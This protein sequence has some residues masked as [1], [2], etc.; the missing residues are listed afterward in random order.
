MK[1][2]TDLFVTLPAASPEEVEVVTL[3]DVGRVM[4]GE[5]KISI[6]K[7]WRPLAG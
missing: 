6:A 3:V 4:K 1:C 7:R 5:E 2:A